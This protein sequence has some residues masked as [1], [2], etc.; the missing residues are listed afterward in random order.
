MNTSEK[1][2]RGFGWVLLAACVLV[3]IVGGIIF[4]SG[5]WASPDGPDARELNDP[6]NQSTTDQ[7]PGQ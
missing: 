3:V 4:W 1:A 5:G 2:S 6:A 7:V